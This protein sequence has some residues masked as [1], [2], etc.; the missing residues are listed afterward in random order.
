M[1]YNINPSIWGESFWNT[2]HILTFAYPDNPTNE[3]KQHI[4]NFFNAVKYILPCETCRYHFEQNL[5]KYPLSDH[6]L[7]TRYTL[8]V[9]LINLHNDVNVRLGK[10]QMSVEAVIQKY[11]NVNTSYDWTT[12]LLLIVLLFFLILYL[13]LN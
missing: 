5:I 7:S 12:T 8:V 11:S 3:D 6:I 1:L 4:V 10:K 2:F 9:W 13:K